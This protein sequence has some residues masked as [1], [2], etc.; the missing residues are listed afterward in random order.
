MYW[1]DRCATEIPAAEV[2]RQGDALVHR[3]GSDVGELDADIH[4][5]RQLADSHEP[6]VPK[7]PGRP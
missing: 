3:H 6:D 5:V 1:C 4:Q 7:G 2:F